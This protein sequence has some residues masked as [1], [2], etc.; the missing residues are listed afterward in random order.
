[1]TTTAVSVTEFKAHCLDVIRQVEQEGTAVD[2]TRH[3]RVV[4]RLVP[5]P[6]MAKGIAPWLRLRGHGKLVGSPEAGV[7]EDSDFDALR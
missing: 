2:L 4:A 3:G 7:L 5:T 6:Q 1:M